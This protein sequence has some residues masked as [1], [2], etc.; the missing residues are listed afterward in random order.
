VPRIS[1]WDTVPDTVARKTIT[2]FRWGEYYS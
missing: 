1:E 2:G